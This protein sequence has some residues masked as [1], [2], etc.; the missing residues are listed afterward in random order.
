MQDKITKSKRLEKITYLTAIVLLFFVGFVSG[1]Y[2]ET[3]DR[4]QVYILNEAKFLKL[5]SMGLALA[6]KDLSNTT[7]AEED[8]KRLK[9]TMKDLSK[10]LNGYSKHPVLIQQKNNQGYELYSGVNKIDI[11]EEVIIKLI[12]KD[13][14]EAIGK[15]LS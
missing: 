8:K 11:T 4:S 2:Y 7:L 5:T 10:Y 9:A 14:W 1:Q 12:G 3:K 6:D 15:A 13:K